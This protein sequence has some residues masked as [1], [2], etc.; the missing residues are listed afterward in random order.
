MIRISKENSRKLSQEILKLNKEKNE[1]MLSFIKNKATQ[2]VTENLPDEIINLLNNK[3]NNKYLRLVEDFEFVSWNKSTDRFTASTSKP[4]PNNFLSKYRGEVKLK[5]KEYNY[6]KNLVNLY[7]KEQTNFRHL[8]IELNNLIYSLKSKKNIVNSFPEF[9]KEI[10]LYFLD[11]K[12]LLP[13][14]LNSIKSRII[15]K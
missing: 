12:K 14:N 7:E 8:L 5:M 1:A 9:E 2:M 13:S 11:N 15:S 6:L 4:L 10:S 3:D